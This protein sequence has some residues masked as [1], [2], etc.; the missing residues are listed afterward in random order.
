MDHHQN[1]PKDFKRGDRLAYQAPGA[2]DFEEV[3]FIRWTGHPD[4]PSGDMAIC[5]QYAD[6]PGGVPYCPKYL[7]LMESKGADAK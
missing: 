1:K 2:E 4:F 5:G 3:F 7:S 6:S